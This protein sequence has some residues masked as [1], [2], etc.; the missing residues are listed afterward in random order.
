MELIFLPYI[1]LA[2]TDI[3]LHAASHK[4]AGGKNG[5]NV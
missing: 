3:M 1:E 2:K 4:V 5:I